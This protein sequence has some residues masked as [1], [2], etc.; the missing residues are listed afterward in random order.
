MYTSW[1]LAAITFLVTFI[2]VFQAHHHFSITEAT[3]YAAWLN[4]G[5]SWQGGDGNPLNTRLEGWMGL[6]CC[7]LELCSLD[8]IRCGT[9]RVAGGRLSARSKGKWQGVLI[10][11]VHAA[12]ARTRDLLVGDGGLCIATWWRGVWQRSGLDVEVLVVRLKVWEGTIRGVRLCRIPG[13][14]RASL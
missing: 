10:S 6:L 7:L 12:V 4:A 1:T 2:L 14:Y 5:G 8:F 11:S 13:V 3:V 9:W